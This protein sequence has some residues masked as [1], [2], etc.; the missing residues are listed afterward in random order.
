MSCGGPGRITDPSENQNRNQNRTGSPCDQ[1]A[2][3]ADTDGDGLTDDCERIVGTDPNN[4]DTDGDTIPDP[5]DEDTFENGGDADQNALRDRL[6]EDVA[7]SLVLG[8]SGLS[9]QAPSGFNVNMISQV[10]AFGSTSK[11]AHLIK[12]FLKPASQCNDESKDIIFYQAEGT[13]NGA[14][15]IIELCGHLTPK[16]LP[17]ASGTGPPNTVDKS[18]TKI[19]KW[20]IGAATFPNS[21]SQATYYSPA[22]LVPDGVDQTTEFSKLLI[23]DKKNCKTNVIND[24]DDQRCKDNTVVYDHLNIELKTTYNYQFLQNL[25]GGGAVSGQTETIDKNWKRKP[26]TSIEDQANYSQG[27]EGLWVSCNPGNCKIN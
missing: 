13:V 12:A 10:M 26:S 6:I 11:I 18:G 1:G 14:P 4:P 19:V 2:T 7:N 8:S 9:G 5:F 22:I 25:P 27:F 21:G 15:T 24:E 23:G 17:G 16:I 3:G 20:D